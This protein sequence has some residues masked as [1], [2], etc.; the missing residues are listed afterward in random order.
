MS[1]IG[2]TSTI[3][4]ARSGPLAAAVLTAC[5]G[6]VGGCSGGGDYVDQLRNGTPAQRADAASYLGAQ[7]ESRAIPALI[8]TLRDTSDE[9]RAKAVWALGMLGAKKALPCVVGLLRDH[10][11]RVRQQAGLALMA[12]EE[13]D[14]ITPL[15][16]AVRMEKDP[17]VR[18]D[19]KR[20]IDYLRQFEGEADLSESGFR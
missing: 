6:G 4:G 3:R 2:L 15:E 9:V 5:L 18:G 11:T 17:W 20:A 16:T 19:L 14:A 13:P 1:G 10:S 8:A 7:R 12:L